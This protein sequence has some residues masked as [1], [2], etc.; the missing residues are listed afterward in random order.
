MGNC[1]CERRNHE[2]NQTT[3]IVHDKKGTEEIQKSFELDNFLQ[4]H[5]SEWVNDNKVATHL[6]SRTKAG[7]VPFLSL[8]KHRNIKLLSIHFDASVLDLWAQYFEKK[9]EQDIDSMIT[10]SDVLT[11]SG[12]RK[13]EMLSILRNG[14]KLQ[15]ME[16]RIWSW[17]DLLMAAMEA[18]T[19]APLSKHVCVMINV[20]PVMEFDPNQKMFGVADPKCILPLFAVYFENYSI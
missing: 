12:C 2:G 10:L 4:V 13:D 6:L 8:H 5:F 1:P 15:Q 11:F 20:V 16:D 17:S 3:V 14:H 9:K 19:K 7:I 18:L